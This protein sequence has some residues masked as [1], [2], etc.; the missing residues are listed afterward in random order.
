MAVVA[1]Q[2]TL[3]IN[4]Y[5]SYLYRDGEE[6]EKTKLCYLVSNTFSSHLVYNTNY[7]ALQ[8]AIEMHA[9]TAEAAN[10]SLTQTSPSHIPK[11][12]TNLINLL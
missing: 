10:L 7:L 2:T 3:Q 5:T 11:I 1:M 4:S 9:T 12:C 6:E 8:N